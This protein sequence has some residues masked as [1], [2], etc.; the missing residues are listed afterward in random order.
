[1]F[2]FGSAE[3]V[4]RELEFLLF[5]VNSWQQN[6]KF[7]KE[8]FTITALKIT[9]DL[10]RGT[11]IAKFAELVFELKKSTGKALVFVIWPRLSSGELTP[12]QTYLSKLKASR[13]KPYI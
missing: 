11:F 9:T 4:S 8:C 1:M 2:V 7:M 10:G 3:K 12:K 5:L 13:K 6:M